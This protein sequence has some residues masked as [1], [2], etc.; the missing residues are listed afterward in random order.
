MLIVISSISANRISILSPEM[1]SYLS[2]LLPTN[3]NCQLWNADFFGWHSFL[4][5]HLCLILC[6][7]YHNGFLA[8]KLFKTVIVLLGY[9]SRCLTSTPQN[10]F[11]SRDHDEVYS[12]QKS[13]KVG[14]GICWIVA[15]K[16]S[17]VLCET[18]FMQCRHIPGN[19]HC[20]W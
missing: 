15:L 7:I 18:S 13:D 6:L 8:N 11:P 1:L 4:D 14:T 12:A 2:F 20:C 9:C 3:R 10:I 16:S 17:W 5:V 19:T